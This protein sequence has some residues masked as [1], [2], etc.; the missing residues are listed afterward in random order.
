M[1]YTYHNFIDEK[2]ITKINS[3]IYKNLS[4]TYPSTYKGWINLLNSQFKYCMVNSYEYRPSSVNVGKHY[5]DPHLLMERLLHYKTLIII[6]EKVYIGL[7]VIKKRK[8]LDDACNVFKKI[9]IY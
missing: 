3:W 4:H 6:D 5:V 8:N 2:F 7:N 9:K 1:E